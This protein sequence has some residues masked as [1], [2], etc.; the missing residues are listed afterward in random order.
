VKGTG[1]LWR[2]NFEYKVT[3][4]IQATINYEGRREGRSNTI[5]IGKAEV[6]AF[7]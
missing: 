3:S 6:R 7:F 2:F 5:H 4:F 1:W